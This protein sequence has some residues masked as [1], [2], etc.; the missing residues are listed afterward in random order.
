MRKILFASL[1]A[2]FVMAPLSCGKHDKDTEKESVSV[3]GCW[4]LASVETKSA[5][6]GD[7]T[8]DVFIQFVE[9]GSFTL[10]QKIGEGWYSKFTGKYTQDKNTISGTYTGGTKTWGPY[11]ME[12]DKTTLVLY[13]EGGVERDSYK[14]IDAIPSTVL[15]MVN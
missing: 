4:E 6:I 10:Y 5:Q 7:V 2:I 3:V 12:L 9:G 15:S 8:V 14:R 1:F 11:E 13:K